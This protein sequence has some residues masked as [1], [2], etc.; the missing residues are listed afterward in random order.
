MISEEKIDKKK[1]NRRNK[2]ATTDQLKDS[3]TVGTLFYNAIP[4]VSGK[5][6]PI[7]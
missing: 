3:R 5:Y 2:I 6:T 4:F 1:N 7:W